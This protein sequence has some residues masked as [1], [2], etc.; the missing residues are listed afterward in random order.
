[1]DS[2]YPP[3]SVVSVRALLLG[4]RI[5]LRDRKLELISRTVGTLADLLQN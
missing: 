2:L 3:H 4:E 5:D 1:M